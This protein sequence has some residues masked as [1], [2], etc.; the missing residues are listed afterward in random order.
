MST[1]NVVPDPVTTERVPPG[2]SAPKST[3][4]VSGSAGPTTPFTW[5]I[6][7][8][9]LEPAT[10]ISGKPRKVTVL[11]VAFSAVHFKLSTPTSPTLG[12]RTASAKATL[13]R[14]KPIASGLLAEPFRPANAVRPEPPMANK[15]VSTSVV[16]ARTIVSLDFSKAKLP[17]TWKNSAT[18]SV[19]LPRARVS[20]PS[21]APMS[22][23]S[24][25]IG[26]VLTMRFWALKST[27]RASAEAPLISTT[28]ES[29]ERVN[30]SSPTKAPPPAVAFSE[31]HLRLEFD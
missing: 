26:P 1:S 5:L 13:E 6:S 19:K 20:C 22:N 28:S 29:P 17:S 18:A 4:R 3:T 8:E 23:V 31:T 9:I 10:V 16:S 12:I 2:E 7:I 27:I 30:V 11:A 15:S 14:D 25:V 24:V 21:S